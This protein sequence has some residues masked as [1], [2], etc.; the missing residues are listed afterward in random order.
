[1]TRQAIALAGS[2]DV[3]SICGDDTA[4]DHYL[5]AAYRSAGGVD[6]LRLCNECVRIRHSMGEPFVPFEGSG[7]EA[8]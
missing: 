8:G 7:H 2:P 1:M 6:T 4:N 5:P 3:C